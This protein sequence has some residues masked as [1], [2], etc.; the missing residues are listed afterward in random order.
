MIRSAFLIALVIGLGQARGG[1]D[2]PIALFDGQTLGGWTR[3]GGKPGNWRA[4]TG[5]IV[6]RGDGK[7]WL[8]TNRE[9]AD[10]D[11]TLEYQLGPGGNSGVLLRAPRRGDP[12]FDGLEIQLLDDDSPAYRRLQPWQY[13]GAV[14]GVVAPR[15]GLA[16]KPGEWN[17]L[18]VRLEGS[19]V[20]VSIN[21][22]VAVDADL[23]QHPEA[24]PKHPGIRR[25]R[26]AIGL[27][28]HGDP[29]RFRHL[30]IRELSGPRAAG[31]SSTAARSPADAAGR[32][33]R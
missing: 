4:A 20:V 12:S 15:R 25:E 16:R 7:D 30:A 9:F 6:C 29:A 10:F 33:S 1:E 2:H 19:R 8:A 23:S 5:E 31:G 18:A 28:S 14:Y 24:L 21:G 27:Q 11:L 26:G 22:E 13:T 32:A 17:T 3:V